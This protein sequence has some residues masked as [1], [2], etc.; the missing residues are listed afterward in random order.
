MVVYDGAEIEPILRR[1]RDM[2]RVRLA[3]FDID[4][5]LIDSTERF[6]KS[7]EE[8]AGR[9]VES[10]E[11][12]GPEER[13]RFWDVFLSP[14]YLH[15]DRPMERGIKELL[16]RRGEGYYILI[17][18]GRPERMREVTVEQLREI[19]V[20]YDALLMR[21]DDDRR[22]DH[23]Y[24]PVRIGMIMR[25]IDSRDASIEYHEDMPKTIEAVRQRFPYIR[26]CV[27]GPGT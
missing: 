10:L 13:N 20:E 5:T 26:I 18:T 12:L 19:G 14:K 22:P 23:I 17:L 1:I 2:D 27:H 24:K 6:R 25:G 4:N 11:E 7:L 3:I 15:L 16:E 9:R 8:V 21:R